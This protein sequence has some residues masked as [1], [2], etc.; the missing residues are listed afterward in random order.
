[1]HTVFNAP[2]ASDS[3]GERL[4]RRETEQE[5][6]GFPSHLF[7]DVSFGSHHTNSS[8]AFPPLLPVQ[9]R[10]DRWIADGP[11]VPLF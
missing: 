4:H 10:S 3:G 6:V 5:I 8:E 1:M 9:I 7:F 2:M 11:L